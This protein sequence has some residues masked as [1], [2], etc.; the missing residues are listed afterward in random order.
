MTYSFIAYI[1][2]SGDDG[3]SGNYREPGGR[4]GSSHWLTISASMWRYSRDL[5]AVQWRNEIRDRLPNGIRNKPIHCKHFDHQKKVMACQLLATKPIRSICVMSN[6]PSI[7]QNV[8]N[9]KNQLYFYLSRYLL[10]RIS[11]FCR[12]TRPNVPEGDGRVKIIFSRRG[13]LSYEGFRD[14]LTKLRQANDPGI[15]INWPVIDISGIEAMDHSKRAGLQIADIVACSMTAGLEPDL[16][17]NCEARYAELLRPIVYRRGRNFLSYGVKIV[18]RP[19][20]LELSD[21]QK[22]FIGVFQ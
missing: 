8:Y 7:P 13:G 10:E 3:I 1:D 14:Y 15:Q 5:E 12:D 9:E 18:P 20:Q 16:Y 2:E 17:G 19:E 21:Q 22:K 4:G 6:K 11:W